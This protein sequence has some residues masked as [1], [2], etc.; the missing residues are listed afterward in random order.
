ML[1]DGKFIW[2]YTYKELKKKKII[3]LEEV[4]KLNTD[5]IILIEIKDINIDIDKLTKLL[6]KYKNKNIYVMS[7]F[8]S[9]IKK[10]KARTFKVGILNYI[11]NS[12]NKY[13]F[14]FIGILYDVASFHMIQSLHDLGI[15]VFLYGI[16][17]KDKLIYEDVYYIV[18]AY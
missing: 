18:D 12:S 14:D 5:K 15:K 10:F 2:H 1:L 7:F 16:N 8:T 11:L 13:P 6:N 3:K 4:L 9:V 17:K